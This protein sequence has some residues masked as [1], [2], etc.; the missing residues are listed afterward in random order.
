VVVVFSGAVVREVGVVGGRLVLV[1][2][3]GAFVVEVVD[4]GG[5]VEV[6]VGDGGGGAAGLVVDVLVVTLVLV[7][8]IPGGRLV[9]VVL[10]PAIGPG[11]ASGAGALCA[12]KRPGLSL[13]MLPPARG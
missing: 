1:V 8:R 6:V 4:L 13:A 7:G 9:V 11:H 2:G 12:T 10:G 5:D 3:S